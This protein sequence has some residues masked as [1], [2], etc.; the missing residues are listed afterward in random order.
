MLLGVVTVKLRK[1]GPPRG[2]NRILSEPQEKPGFRM[3]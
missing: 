2:K 1:R 3:L